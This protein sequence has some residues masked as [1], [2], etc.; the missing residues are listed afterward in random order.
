MKAILVVAVACLFVAA[1]YAADAD[2]GAAG[3]FKKCV[4]PVEGTFSD[5]DCKTLVGTYEQQW[6][7]DQSGG[8]CYTNSVSKTSIKASC[9]SRIS[10]RSYTQ[11]DCEGPSSVSYSYPT[12]KCVQVGDNFWKKVECASASTISFSVALLALLAAFALLL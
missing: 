9:G 11:S 6:A 8:K 5:K 1:A 2:C 12:G 4:G 10:T 7:D 3:I